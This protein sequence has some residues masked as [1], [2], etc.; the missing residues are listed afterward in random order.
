MAKRMIQ[1]MQVALIYFGFAVMIW[2]M[3]FD[4]IFGWG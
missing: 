1:F 2:L 4:L 3:I